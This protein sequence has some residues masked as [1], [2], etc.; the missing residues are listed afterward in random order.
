MAASVGDSQDFLVDSSYDYNDRPE[1]SATLKKI[2]DYG[3]FYSEDEYYINLSQ[4]E[5]IKFDQ[6]LELLSENFDNVIY[7]QMREIFGEEWNPG[8]DGDER[9]TILF[10]KT[11]ENVGGYFN[12]NDEY[13]K[14]NIVDEKSNEREMLYLN[15]IFI[16]NERIESFLAHEFQHMIT[17]YHKTKLR[18]ITDDIWLNEARSEY[19]ST[20]IGYDDNY[21]SSNLRARADNLMGNQT[22]SLTEWKNKIYDYSSVNLFSQYIADHFG[23]QIFRT[24]IGD[25]SVGIQSIEDSL[26]EEGYPETTFRDIFSN[27]TIANYINNRTFSEDSAYGYMN[28]NLNYDNFHFKP[29]NS[30]SIKQGE[31]NSI[32]ISN[33]LKDWSSKYYKFIGDISDGADK[34]LEIKFNG[35]NSGNFGV[36]YI[37]FKN[38]QIIKVEKL[39]LDDQQDARLYI[40]NFN[41]DVSSLV[42]IPS[43]EKQNSGFGGD[44]NSYPFSISAKLGESIIYPDGSLLE[45]INDPKVYLIENGKKRWFTS[46]AA[47]ISGGYKWENITQVLPDELSIYSN[48]ENI[49]ALGSKPN[50]SLIKASGP[51]VYLIENGKKRWFTSA[52]AFIS[53]GYK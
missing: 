16:G 38:D 21:A 47:F 17:W 12:P 1:I 4:A 53:R 31:E 50:G 51:E 52:A 42:L 30:Y 36:S 10:T 39:I 41:S 32:E 48:G 9:I 18:N 28:A 26:K 46:A 11:Q 15:S 19:S 3:Y 44:I 27:W 6:D 8:I 22:D 24:M 7:P 34:N 35:D 14:E 20:V 33:T 29:T 25:A 23:S 43:S 45:S 40:E 37:L 5:K 49:S 2:S 13:K